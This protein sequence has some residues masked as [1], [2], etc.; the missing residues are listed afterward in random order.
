[1][2]TIQ[3]ERYARINHET[4]RNGAALLVPGRPWLAP[5]HQSACP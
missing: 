1:M 3:K 4:L 2:P 5:A